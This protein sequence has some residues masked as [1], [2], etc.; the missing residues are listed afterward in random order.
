MDPAALRP[1]DR[2]DFLARAAW[3]SIGVT[4][5][6]GRRGRLDLAPVGRAEAAQGARELR[7]ETRQIKW[8]LAP[9][10]TSMAIAQHRRLQGP[11][12]RRKEG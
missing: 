1:L 11:K 8:D 4:S 2:R 3:A 12:I 6:L 5:L 7:L 9:G 10:R